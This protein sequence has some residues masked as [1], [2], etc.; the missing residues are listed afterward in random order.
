[1]VLY[2]LK[3]NPKDTHTHTPISMAESS[4]SDDYY[5]ALVEYLDKDR[6]ALSPTEHLLPISRRII[7]KNNSKL[8]QKF[9][10]RQII[11]ATIISWLLSIFVFGFPIAPPPLLNDTSSLSN[12]P[13]NRTFLEG[14][15]TFPPIT[16]DNSTNPFN[17]NWLN[18]TQT[19]NST[20]FGNTSIFQPP[21]LNTS[22]NSNL[23]GN[24]SGSGPDGGGGGGGPGMGKDEIV[25]DS[26]HDLNTTDS[27]DEEELPH[28]LYYAIYEPP[29]MLFVAIWI[30]LNLAL[31]LPE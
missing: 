20:L 22:T 7:E 4:R 2:I 9:A 15:F 14:N 13:P 25:D 1:M 10:I 27:E 12:I 5:R 26:R 24:G 31:L 6:K 16:L 8:A 3:S 17:N 21:N 28:W 18:T 19:T 11:V 30:D 29:I 23:P